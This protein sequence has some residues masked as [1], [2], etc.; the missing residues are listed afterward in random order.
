[1][2]YSPKYQNIPWL[3]IAKT[4]TLDDYVVPDDSLFEVLDDFDDSDLLVY[5]YDYQK[6]L[7]NLK[8]TPIVQAQS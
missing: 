5:L 7:L 4:K 6:L 2:G 8:L 1:M 3:F